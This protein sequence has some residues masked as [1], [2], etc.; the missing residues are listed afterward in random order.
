LF[1]SINFGIAVVVI[2]VMIAAVVLERDRRDYLGSLFGAAIGLAVF[3][4]YVVTEARVFIKRSEGQSSI[5]V[6][7]IICGL[8][9][10]ISAVLASFIELKEQPNQSFGSR[11]VVYGPLFLSSAYAIGCGCYRVTR[12]KKNAGADSL[13]DD[14]A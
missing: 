12:F 11:F 6:W 14:T 3:V 7:N 4:P 9:L 13:H 10:F 5:G 1:F 2:L 8:G